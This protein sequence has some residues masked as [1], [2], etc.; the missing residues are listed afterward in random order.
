MCCEFQII[1]EA[2]NNS[3][4]VYVLIGL[5]NNNKKIVKLVRKDVIIIN[6]INIG[7]RRADKIFTLNDSDNKSLTEK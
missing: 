2:K 7:K 5:S 4:N 6:N 1:F 3:S